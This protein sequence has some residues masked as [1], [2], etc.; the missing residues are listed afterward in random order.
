MDSTLQKLRT[1][2]QDDYCNG[3][4]VIEVQ[5]EDGAAT[6]E[7]EDDFALVPDSAVLDWNISRTSI[8][9]V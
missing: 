2:I 6:T 8:S 5:E 3:D 7:S 9:V 1:I 4:F